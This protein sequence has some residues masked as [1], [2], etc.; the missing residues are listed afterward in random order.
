MQRIRR[1]LIDLRRGEPVYLAGTQGGVLL[2]ALENL[3]DARLAAI[4]PLANG[5]ATLLMTAH[6]AQALGIASHNLNGLAIDLAAL[7]T[8]LPLSQL[9]RVDTA[10]QAPAQAA[11]ALQLDALDLARWAGLMPSLLAFPANAQTAPLHGE[12]ANGE[13][14][15]LAQDDVAAF[16]HGQAQPPERVSEARV[17]LAGAEQSRFVL[18]READGLHEHVALLINEPAQWPDP[19]ALRMHSACL[20]GDLFG[21]LRCDCG[22]QLRGAVSAI[23]A[24]GGGILLYLAQEGRGIGL[25]NKLRAYGLQDSG[26][27]TVDADQLLGFGEDERRYGVAAAILADLSINEVTLLTNNPAKIAAL[28]A[29]GI[30][31][32]GR[33]PVHGALNTHNARY[34]T[35]KAERAGHWLDELLAAER[36][37]SHP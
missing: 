18:Y 5:A 13:I 21:S 20:T 36:S 29:A 31:I 32:A 27:D 10:T 3:S 2:L 33:Q 15:A 22:E 19:P 7:P 11:S 4:E 35:A 37:R 26:L 28:E 1:A 17:P 23:A 8:P 30:T 14:L 16:I 6:R 24:E 9:M 12:I 34:L 25:A